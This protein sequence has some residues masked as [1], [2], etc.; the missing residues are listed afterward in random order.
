MALLPRQ[1]CFTGP[2]L[3]V[4]LIVMLDGS[5]PGEM[6]ARGF[7]NLRCRG[8]NCESTAVLTD[9]RDVSTYTFP[10]SC[11]LL[12]AWV[13]IGYLGTMVRKQTIMDRND[14][15]RVERPRVCT[16]LCGACESGK[17]SN[18]PPPLNLKCPCFASMMLRWFDLMAVLA[19]TKELYM[20][21]RPPVSTQGSCQ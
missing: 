14:Q 13:L 12:R 15:V 4:S 10:C 19:D 20:G 6:V 1:R 5:W 16:C 9:H 3:Q 18:S 2:S 7:A 21:R 17:P 8:S 11:H